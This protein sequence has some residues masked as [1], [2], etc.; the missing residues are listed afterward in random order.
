MGFSRFRLALGIAVLL[1]VAYSV[2][3]VEM[4]QM[5][6]NVWNQ[7]S[8]LMGDDYRALLHKEKHVLRSGPGGLDW[9]NRRFLQHARDEQDHYVESKDKEAM[10]AGRQA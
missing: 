6:D 9:G 5:L 3:Y 7:Q 8:V 4:S 10:N 2:Q 1:S